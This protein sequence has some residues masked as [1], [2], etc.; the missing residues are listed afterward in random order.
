[1]QWITLANV[2]SSA[3]F[4][5]NEFWARKLGFSGG[6]WSLGV[7]LGIV[8][9]SV[10][11]FIEAHP[12]NL[13]TSEPGNNCHGADRMH[14]KRKC[15]PAVQVKCNP[16]MVMDDIYRALMLYTMPSLTI[17]TVIQRSF[18]LYNIS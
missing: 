14:R 17:S 1:M 15:D 8:S 13:A 10:F 5:R 16:L 12:D 18:S 6:D 11:I 4:G 9:F 7:F 2:S 3:I